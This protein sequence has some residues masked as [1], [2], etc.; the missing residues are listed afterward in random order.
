MLKYNIKLAWL[1]I[2]Q[3][4]WLTLLMVLAIGIGVGIFMTA[5]T[6]VY[7]GNKTDLP[8]K[9]DRLF[10]MQ[11]DSRSPSAEPISH[12]ND[13][14]DMTYRDA[15]N[16]YQLDRENISTTFTW[17][18]DQIVNLDSKSVK[19]YRGYSL[20]TTRS[21]FSIFDVPFLFGEPWSEEQERTSAPV[22]VLTK[23]RNDYLFGGAN[24]IGKQLRID[25]HI[26]T[27]VGVIDNW[28]V[29]YRFYDRTFM[30]GLSDDAYLPYKF[31]IANDLARNARF[32]C[33]DSTNMD[34]QD[35]NTAQL[36]A[37]ECGW[38][39]FWAE[40][41]DASDVQ[42]Y[43]SSID[44]YVEQQRT[45]GRFPRENNNMLTSLDDVMAFVHNN[46]VDNKFYFIIGAL[47]MAA[48]VFSAVG[49]ILAKFAR[50]RKEVSVRR[51]LGAKR[52]VLILQYIT[53]I[54]LIGLIGGM[55]GVFVSLGALHL[56][57]L[58]TFHASGF[59]VHIS[60]L[61][62]LFRFD[63]PMFLVAIFVAISS[64][65]LV[66]II[67]ILQVCNVQISRYLTTD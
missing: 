8:H 14:V 37:S 58:K 12:F 16:L 65:I 31:S 45:L 50:K 63:W 10:L 52:K 38:V 5:M 48:C 18:T 15:L 24:S 41:K 47:F 28:N 33:W 51:A 55:V 46:N 66:G 13:M 56:M 2:L 30:Q 35:R 62:T 22:I 1:S 54:G 44:Q 7:Q 34:F 27:V 17:L 60:D 53:E 4:P 49:V 32:E 36:V 11:L 19:P 25:N 3:R 20:V 57:K 23:A 59:Y 9:S 21:F 29:R 61:D 67:P 64:A 39:T 6:V 42:A 43:K 40:L 26:V